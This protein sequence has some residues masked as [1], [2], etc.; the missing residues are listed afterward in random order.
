M[1]E[2]EIRDALALSSL[3]V[4]FTR[5]GSFYAATA[6][7]WRTRAIGLANKGMLGCLLAGFFAAR[8]YTDFPIDLFQTSLPAWTDLSAWPVWA[9]RNLLFVLDVVAVLLTV[10]MLWGYLTL[11]SPSEDEVRAALSQSVRQ[12]PA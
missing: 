11:R 4:A 10:P 5:E 12:P 3:H 9:R 7:G 2:R 6:G 8:L 1:V